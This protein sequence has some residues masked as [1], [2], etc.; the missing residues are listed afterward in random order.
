M[1]LLA[2]ALLA[3]A[4]LAFEVLLVR[5]FAIEQ[6][7]HFAYMAIGVAM[8]GYGASGTALA[9]MRLSARF[10][11]TAFPVAAVTASALFLLAPLAADALPF[12]ATQLAL[13]PGQWWRL[14]LLY[15][16]LALPFA[17]EAVA[18]VVALAAEP[19][20]PGR[21]YGAS[22][23]G[24]ALG[25][26]S[27]VL[28]LFVLDPLRAIGLPV[29]LSAAGAAVAAFSA[30][31]Y[32][33]LSAAALVT[34]AGLG[35]MARPPWSLDLTP[36]K[37]LPQVEAYPDARRVAEHGDPAGWVT[38][39]EAGAFRHA[40]GLSLGYR[41]A[42]PAQTALFVDGQLAGAATAWKREEETALLSWLPAAIPH[43]L[44][45][46]P[47]VLVIGAGD[48]TDVAT[49]LAH[50]AE[51]VTALELHP[52]LVRIQQASPWPRGP[53][54]TQWIVGDARAFVAR[55]SER[56]DLIALGPAG[57][58]GASGGGVHS[59]NEDFL[60]TEDA[61][62]A[63]LRRLSPGGLLTITRWL[64]VPP[65]ASVR[66]ILTAAR[67][68]RSAGADP[69]AGLVVVRSWGTVTMLARPSGFSREDL[70]TLRSWC[71]SRRFDVDW[72][73][74]TAGGARYNRMSEPTLA[75]AAA[76][77]AAGGEAERS[78]VG[79]YPFRVEPVGD[80]R[81]Y[82]HHFLDLA[83]L[84]RLLA[85][86]R[87]D[88][89]PFAE[90]GFLALA[91][92]LVQSVVLATLFI[93]APV[94]LALRRARVDV[95]LLSYFTLIGFAYLAAEIAAIQQ[96]ALLLGH[97]VYAVAAVLAVTLAGSGAGSLWSDRASVP[98]AAALTAALALLLVGYAAGLLSIVHA[99]H[100]R[101][102]AIRIVAALLVLVPAAFLMGTPFAA[103][104][105]A[106]AGNDPSRV[107]WAWA[108][109][110][111]ASVIAAPLSAL[112][113][114]ETGTP[115]LFAA[116]AA[117]YALSAALLRGRAA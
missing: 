69:A 39:V 7:H 42:F 6:F 103:G 87:G 48:G 62:A 114:L 40:P 35:A 115:A 89:L 112:M 86:T 93:V 11:A 36:Y 27:S 90:W 75:D 96:L 97:P 110:G 41:G 63:Y 99:L 14:G 57:G 21:I 73:A 67:A 104:L 106:L 59:L 61:Y 95:P 65:R 30:H 79:G 111:F 38:A 85:T 105:R 54:R 55:S 32:G 84:R 117:A 78:F 116:A 53:G 56:F 92:T 25:A 12:D 37:S 83:T 80:T 33:L 4:T 31:R 17:A 9:A 34:A 66:V 60:H 100:G 64:D 46:T 15:T 101:A 47:R 82:P 76:A 74:G 43:A 3:A 98:R 71:G 26:V 18:L 107:A 5:L 8:L 108:M 72:P 88:W 91:A 20:R 2:V 16:A 70:A 10:V 102:A 52:D 24:A 49:A 51:R 45:D 109:N 29:L 13:Q 19:L 1:K 28:V 94:A 77:G 23:A 50:G 58:F 81:P 68:L 44:G 113:A 22:F